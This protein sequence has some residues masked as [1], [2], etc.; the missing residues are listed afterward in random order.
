MNHCDIFSSLILRNY[1]FD[2]LYLVGINTMAARGCFHSALA[3]GRQLAG[4][5]TDCV[6]H[7]VVVPT[8]NTQNRLLLKR[9]LSPRESSIRGM[10]SGP[11]ADAR[12]ANGLTV[13]QRTS[14]YEVNKRRN[15]WVKLVWVLDN[16]GAAV[17]FNTWRH[18]KKIARVCVCVDFFLR[19]VFRV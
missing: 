3:Y 13:L 6:R 14:K 18:L 2:G 15:Y 1:F 17:A 11:V 10:A 16:Q 19:I 8:T 12:I 5:S 4:S 7:S 9:S